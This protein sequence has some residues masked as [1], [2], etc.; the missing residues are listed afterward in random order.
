M[1]VS[2]YGLQV[3]ISLQWDR[4]EVQLAPKPRV[5]AFPGRMAGSNSSGLQQQLPPAPEEQPG[6]KQKGPGQ[7]AYD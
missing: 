4:E 6:S 3:E 5:G 7:S 1:M 2:D